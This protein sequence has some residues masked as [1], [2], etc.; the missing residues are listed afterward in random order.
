MA[1]CRHLATAARVKY[2]VACSGV[3]D[4]QVVPNIATRAIAV[5]TLP[6]VFISAMR[7]TADKESG[8][9]LVG[10]GMQERTG[11][12]ALEEEMPAGRAVSI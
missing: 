4:C 1:A 6:Y 2:P 3:F 8:A 12:P 10:V 5:R 11:C 7:N 9:L